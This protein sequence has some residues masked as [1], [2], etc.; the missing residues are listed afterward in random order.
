MD[1]SGRVWLMIGI[2]QIKD[3]KDM[4]LEFFMSLST[5]IMFRIEDCKYTNQWHRGETVTCLGQRSK[6]YGYSIF[7]ALI[8]SYNLAK[9]NFDH[10]E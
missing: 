10:S 9:N 7:H 5:H 2:A 8:N 1:W 3:P 4:C 6:G